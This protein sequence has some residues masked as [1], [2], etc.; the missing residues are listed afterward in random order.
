MPG[1]D[2]KLNYEVILDDNDDYGTIKTIVKTNI[3]SVV[4]DLSTF[5]QRTMWSPPTKAP[6]FD[7]IVP[8]LI[9]LFVW[10]FLF[11]LMFN[12]YRISKYKNA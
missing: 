12:L 11:I 1:T 2:G 4:K 5:D 8:N 10:G 9:I 7:L 3:G 6:L